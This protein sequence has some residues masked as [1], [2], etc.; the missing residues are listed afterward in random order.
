MA[1][2]AVSGQLHNHG[3]LPV[4]ELGKLGVTGLGVLLLHNAHHHRVRRLCARP[5]RDEQG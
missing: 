3:R 5:A 1:V 4:Q 2:R